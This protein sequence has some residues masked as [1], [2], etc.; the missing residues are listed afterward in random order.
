MRDGI[1][2]F[3]IRSEEIAV[4]AIA[5]VEKDS[6]R[7]FD[8]S[9]TIPSSAWSLPSTGCERIETPIGVLRRRRTSVRAFLCV[10]FQRDLKAKREKSSFG[11]KEGLM[12]ISVS[13]SK[14]KERGC[15]FFRGIVFSLGCRRTRVTKHFLKVGVPAK[16][17]IAKLARLLH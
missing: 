15:I 3:Y 8:N 1:F 5:L 11:S 16:D 2:S 9:H 6:I 4:R 13:G 17:C 10:D 14:S 12:Q 7:G